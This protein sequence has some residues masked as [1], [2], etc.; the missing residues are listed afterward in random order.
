MRAPRRK[1]ERFLLGLNGT[2]K[3][4]W[5]ILVAKVKLIVC[6]GNEIYKFC[7]ALPPIMICSTAAVSIYHGLYHH[8]LNRKL[9]VAIGY[10]TSRACFT[11]SL[12][13]TD[14]AASNE[15]LGAF[16]YASASP[17]EHRVRFYD[18]FVS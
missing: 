13:E 10:L 12:S 2:T 11:A 3:S 5:H 14:A 7:L 17:K 9:W 1:R 18:C 6:W 15:R 4:T 8:P 16:Q